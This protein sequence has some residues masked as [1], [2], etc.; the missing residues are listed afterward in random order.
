[1]E[2]SLFVLV[3][4]SSKLQQVARK[5]TN[6]SAVFA[7]VNL[8]LSVHYGVG[9]RVHQNVWF[10]IVEQIAGEESE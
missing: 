10:V 8:I 3:S 6:G 1:M 4:V 2:S 9:R 5:V 7:C